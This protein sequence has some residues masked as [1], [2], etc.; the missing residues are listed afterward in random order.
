MHWIENISDFKTQ[1]FH[2]IPLILNPN[3]QLIASSD[4]NI[5]IK[6]ISTNVI[7][8]DYS[9]RIRFNSFILALSFQRSEENS[10][11]LLSFSFENVYKAALSSQLDYDSWKILE[12]HTKPLSYW[13]DWDKCKKLR[14]ALAEK[15]L[16]RNWPINYLSKIFSDKEVLDLLDSK[17]KKWKY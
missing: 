16:D 4:I 12:V 11:K 1:L 8:N 14:N 5:W 3:S 6:L 9:D 10:F 15:F 17:L 7:I 13:K 2:L